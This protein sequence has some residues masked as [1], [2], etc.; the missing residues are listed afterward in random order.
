MLPAPA[1]PAVPR[2][3]GL[4][5]AGSR[6]GA[7]LQV[8]QRLRDRGWRVPVNGVFDGPTVVV[9]RR[10][11]SEKGLVVDGRV[12]RLT[13]TA[14]WRAHRSPDVLD[15]RVDHLVP[16]N[17]RARSPE[18]RLRRHGRRSSA[19]LPTDFD[20]D[21]F[22]GDDKTYLL[23]TQWGRQ[24]ESRLSALASLAAGVT[25]EPVDPAIPG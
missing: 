21:P 16:A 14:L 6:G 15:D 9:V 17:L 4:V 1:G 2:F 13:W 11:Q 18:R 25:F 20:S 22:H 3:P 5:Q 7:V 24:T 12:G 8:Q 10:F 19:E 23:T